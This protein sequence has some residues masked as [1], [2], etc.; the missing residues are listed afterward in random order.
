[1][2]IV[3]RIIIN[4]SKMLIVLGLIEYVAPGL[5]YQASKYIVELMMGG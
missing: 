4:V 5:S 1:M 2:I 3:F